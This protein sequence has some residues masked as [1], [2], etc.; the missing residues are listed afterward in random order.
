MWSL[1]AI[2]PITAS[3][4]SYLAIRNIS[5]IK[6]KL[7]AFWSLWAAV[8]M[9]LHVLLNLNPLLLPSYPLLAFFTGFFMY[10]GVGKVESKGRTEG[11][12]QKPGQL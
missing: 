2:P 4:I 10:K 11:S 3:V 6:E 8:S 9:S 1:L 12:K 5:G 7:I